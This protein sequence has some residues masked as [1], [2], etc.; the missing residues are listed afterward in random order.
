MFY[1]IVFCV[2]IVLFFIVFE[3]IDY[4]AI[5]RY[6]EISFCYIGS[7]PFLIF[8]INI[9]YFIYLFLLNYHIVSTIFIYV[10]YSSLPIISNFIYPSIILYSILSFILFFTIIISPSIVITILSFSFTFIADATAFE[11]YSFQ[12]ALFI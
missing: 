9:S 12:T 11:F 6:F 1:T 4:L 8:N 7:L 3:F 2:N 10:L 5:M